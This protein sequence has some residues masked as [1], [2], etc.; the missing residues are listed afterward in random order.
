MIASCSIGRTLAKS[1]PLA[2]NLSLRMLIDGVAGF[3]LLVKLAIVGRGLDDDATFCRLA[4][5][6]KKARKSKKK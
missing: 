3:C 5:L 1:T 6:A 4:S 2:M